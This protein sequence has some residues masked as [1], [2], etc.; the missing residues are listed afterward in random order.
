MSVLEYLIDNSII[1][2][3]KITQLENRV[4]QMEEENKWLKTQLEKN[5]VVKPTMPTSNKIGVISF[6]LGSSIYSID[7]QFVFLGTESVGMKEVYVV[8]LGPVGDS[9]I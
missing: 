5:G 1:K 9:K 2:V 7:D 8:I 6:D 4:I 3:P